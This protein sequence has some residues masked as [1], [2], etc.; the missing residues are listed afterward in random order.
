M[1]TPD[2]YAPIKKVSAGGGEV[3]D[4]TVLDRTR[5]ER[6]NRFPWFLPDGRH[7]LYTAQRPVGFYNRSTVR[8]GSLNSL[9]SQVLF[10][11][12]SN[13]M[14]SNGFLLYIRE[15][16]STLVAEP[17]DP[18]NLRRTG[19]PLTVAE[20]VGNI[21]LT[22]CGVFTVS[23]NGRLVYQN[24]PDAP[25]LTWVDLQGKRIVAPG[26]EPAMNVGEIHFTPTRSYL[27]ANIQAPTGLGSNIWIYDVG[28][29]LLSAL[30]ADSRTKGAGILSPDGRVAV[31][32]AVNGGPGGWQDL[33]RQAVDKSSGE[34]P[35]VTSQS[36][37]R[38]SSWSADGK[39]LL[40]RQQFARKT[41]GLVRS[42]GSPRHRCPRRSDLVHGSGEQWGVLARW[43]IHRLR[44]WCDRCYRGV[45]RPP[46]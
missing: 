24:A 7:F 40:F 16:T 34:Q 43:A 9:T 8:L 38:P 35:L 11:A 27:A 46:A 12:D 33:Y 30:T 6:T 14:F 5:G 42:D 26:F 39:F 36:N 10:D 19:Q 2:Y 32:D 29:T 23:S 18:E 4:A 31:Y 25:P 17:F 20:G 44:F 45:R 41:N 3:T 21:R 13:V 15:N 28:R 22:S 1:F 37:K